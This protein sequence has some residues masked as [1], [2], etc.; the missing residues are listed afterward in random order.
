MKRENRGQCEREKCRHLEK[1]YSRHCL[2]KLKHCHSN[3]RYMC[4]K[5]KRCNTVVARK[6]CVPQE[7]R[8]LSCRRI[9]K[10]LD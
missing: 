9:M 6:L 8:K 1:T 10:L 3:S 7:L 5:A 2:Q 4:L